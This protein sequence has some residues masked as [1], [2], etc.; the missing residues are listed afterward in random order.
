MTL[1][2]DRG[3]SV[4]DSPCIYLDTEPSGCDHGI[5]IEGLLNTVEIRSPSDDH[6]SSLSLYWSPYDD[7]PILNE[8]VDE[9]M[10]TLAQFLSF[11]LL[12]TRVGIWLYSHE[13]V[14]WL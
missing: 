14:V 1:T 10:M 13:I 6:P 8:A 9:L 5:L 3:V 7:D 11:T 2:E 12:D 4:L